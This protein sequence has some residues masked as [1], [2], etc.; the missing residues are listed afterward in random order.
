MKISSY[1][2]Q[3]LFKFFIVGGVNTLVGYSLYALFIFFNMD[4]YLAV[5]FA[6]V[7]GVLFN[8]KTTGALVFKN[9]DQSRLYRFIGVYTLTYILNIALITMLRP[10]ISNTYLVGFFVLI[11]VALVTFIL[12][13]FLVFKD[14]HEI[15]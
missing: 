15:N 11:P 14:A 12:N 3:Q 7:L 13:K 9:K 1:T 6:T 2:Q 5:L 10:V 8:F 4:Y